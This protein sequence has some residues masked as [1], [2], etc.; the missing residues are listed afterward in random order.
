MPL[1]PTPQI[2]VSE[3]IAARVSSRC[4]R[5]LGRRV[6]AAARRMG[7]EPEALASLALRIVNDEEMAALH[8]RF[9]GEAGPTDVLSF[10]S[11]GG[12]GAGLGDLAID[13]QAVERQAAGSSERALFDEATVLAVH[14]LAHLLGHDHRE[15]AE[16]RRMHRLERRGLR[17]VAVADPPRPYV[18]RLIAPAID[19]E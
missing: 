9:M 6:R 18:P 16:G 3:P 13:W 2:L 19:D 8:L 17:A 11:A 5:E 12:F 15:R 7:I 14:G 10:E 1:Y 4:V